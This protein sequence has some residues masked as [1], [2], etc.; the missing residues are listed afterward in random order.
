MERLRE[1]AKKLGNPG[2]DKLYIAARKR[3]IPAT[4]SQVKQLISAIG[5]KQIFKPLPRSSGVTAAEDVATR[6]QADLID[7]HTKP[8]VANGVTY[9]YVLVLV[10]VFTRECWAEAVENKTSAMVAP[11]LLRILERM[12]ERPVY[13]STD[14]G[15]EWKGEVDQM[16]KTQGRARFR[17]LRRAKNPRAEIIR[18]TKTDAADRNAIAVVDRVIQNLK[19]RIDKILHT[20]P[21]QG[22]ADT[23][24]RVV[25]SYNATPHETVHGAPEDVRDNEIQKFLVTQDNSTKLQDNQELLEKRKKQ[26]E[27]AGAFRGPIRQAGPITRGFKP[28]YATVVEVPQR[29]TGSVIHS[30]GPPIDIKRVQI[31]AEETDNQLWV[32]GLSERDIKKKDKLM[33]MMNRLIDFLADGEHSI[34]S[35]AVY[36]K[37][38][39]GI[40]YEERLREANLGRL[41][42]AIR[43]FPQFELTKKNYYVKMA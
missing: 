38:K 11:A 15:T 3:G 26:L 31:V 8:T 17:Y 21:D 6:F 2:A 20:H 23:L 42:D 13:I 1:L 40:A 25:S 36:L 33:P 39:M 41:V 5:T 24:V 34:A 30:D 19:V 18:R 14:L 9:R 43:L 7:Y 27:T 12:P 16:L 32:G 35:A 29:V 10:D 4:R 37:E 22:W 28:S